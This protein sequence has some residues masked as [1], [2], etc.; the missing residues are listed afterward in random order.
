MPAKQLDHKEHQ[1]ESLM[2]ESI[3][4]TQL[5]ERVIELHLHQQQLTHVT[6]VC[7]KQEADESVNIKFTLQMN[8]KFALNF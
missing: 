7:V 6:N 2:K 8:G 5:K 1:L 4:E 3:P